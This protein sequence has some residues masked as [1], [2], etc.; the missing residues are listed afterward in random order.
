[1]GAPPP[2]LKELFI[3]EMQALNPSVSE[4]K[5]RKI[6]ARMMREAV[7]KKLVEKGNLL[8]RYEAPVFIFQYRDTPIL[9][10]DIAVSTVEDIDAGVYEDTASTRNQR[11]MAREAITEYAREMLFEDVL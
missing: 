10:W 8:I 7:A 6:R 4:P 11:K 5:L 3:M 2:N 1:M 9:L